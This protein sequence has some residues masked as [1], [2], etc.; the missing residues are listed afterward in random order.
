MSAALTAQ[1][2]EA[3]VGKT[4]TPGGQPFVL[5]LVSVKVTEWPGWDDTQR[6]PF[7][8]ILRGPSSGVLPEGLYEVAVEDGP[9]LTLYIIPIHTVAGDRQD[10]QVVFN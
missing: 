1:D 7:T 3:H 10:Y 2:F 6:K 8:L 9:A 5:T 4:L